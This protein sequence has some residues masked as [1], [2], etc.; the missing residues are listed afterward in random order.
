M[1]KDQLRD[2][3]ESQMPEVTPEVVPDTYR[4]NVIDDLTPSGNLGIELGVAAGSFSAKM[5]ASGKF[6]RFWGVDMYADSHNTA[7]YKAAL[8][9]VGLD[10]NYH[11]LR[12]TF[13][14]AIDLFPDG[15]F[16]FIYVDGYAHTGEEGG[17]TLL[18][19]YAK[20]KPGGIMAGDDYDV[21]SWPL[22]VWAVH[23]LVQQLGLHLKITDKAGDVTYNRYRSWFFIKP[24]RVDNVVALS[25]NATLMQLGDAEKQRRAEATKAKMH[26]RKHNRKA[27]QSIDTPPP[28]N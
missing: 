28:G 10:Q 23:D 20:L 27:A 22:V 19:W 16:D 6:A 14:Q 8:R 13:D 15:Y 17:R 5:V 25:G 26:A 12:M 18:N 21:K 2:I 7:E 24:Q 4:W 9:L 3:A 11:L 1:Q